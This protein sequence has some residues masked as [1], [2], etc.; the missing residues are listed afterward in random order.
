MQKFGEGEVQRDP[1]DPQGVVSPAPQ[2]GTQHEGAVQEDPQEALREEN[3]Q[4]DAAPGVY[5][6]DQT[7]G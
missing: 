5:P 2:Q 6:D 7:Q 1:L 4:A 3:D